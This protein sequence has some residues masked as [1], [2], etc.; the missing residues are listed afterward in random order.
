MNEQ[1]WKPE[2]CLEHEAEVERLLDKGYFGVWGSDVDRVLCEA[3]YL[4]KE[5]QYA[6]LLQQDAD[7]NNRATS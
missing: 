6:L 1:A 4:Y 3:L 2:E 7:G 5:Q